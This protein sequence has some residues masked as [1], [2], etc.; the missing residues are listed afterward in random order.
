MQVLSVSILKYKLLRSDFFKSTTILFYRQFGLSLLQSNSTYIDRNYL[1]TWKPKSPFNLNKFKVSFFRPA[2]KPDFPLEV[3]QR[4]SKEEKVQVIGLS[5]T[6]QY[7]F[8]ILEFVVKSINIL[9]YWKFLTSALQ[10][11]VWLQE[12]NQVLT[13]D[14]KKRL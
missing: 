4:I 3:R 12:E 7:F 11:W 13:P 14:E 8:S 5:M 9:S 6:F 2:L 1:S 10:C